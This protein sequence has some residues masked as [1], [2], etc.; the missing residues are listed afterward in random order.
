[1]IE[2]ERASMRRR[3]NMHDWV[4]LLLLFIIGAALLVVVGL[5]AVSFAEPA[6]LVYRNL[7]L[8]ADGP[9]H[10]GEAVSLHVDRCN[11]LDVPLYLESARTL[12]DVNTGRFYSIP[13]GNGLA[14]PGCSL[15]T[16][17][18]SIVPEDAPDG[19]YV[20]NAVVRVY[21]R[22]GRRFDIP[23]SSQPFQVIANEGDA[24]A[25]N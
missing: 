15:A 23:Y 22:W 1:M 2:A 5:I 9:V 25:R 17:A 14:Q 13:S 24:S 16:V 4:S 6:P 12:R 18:T 20:V 10:Q 21:G 7:P 11:N 8:P 19:T 3:A